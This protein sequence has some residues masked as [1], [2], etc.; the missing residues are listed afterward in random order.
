MD[1]EKDDFIRLNAY[2]IEAFDD[3]HDIFINFLSARIVLPHH[4][5]YCLVNAKLF[6]SGDYFVFI[7]IHVNKLCDPL[8]LQA[9]V[10]PAVVSIGW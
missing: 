2:E 1:G 10:M 5:L 7:I 8:N 9:A 6:C 4:L 3:I